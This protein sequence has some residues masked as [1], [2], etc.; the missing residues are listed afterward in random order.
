[1]AKTFF[2]RYA[3]ILVI[4]VVL[5]VLVACAPLPDQSA[6]D[7]FT[8]T[9]SMLDASGLYGVGEDIEVGGIISD[10]KNQSGGKELSIGYPVVTKFASLPDGVR[11]ADFRGGT[12][13]EASANVMKDQL[14]V[15][16]DSEGNFSGSCWYVF[17]EET[18]TNRT[19]DAISFDVSQGQFALRDES[20]GLSYVGTDRPLWHDAWDG[21]NLKQYWIV[22]I[23]AG[24]TLEL[25]LLYAL[26]N[27]VIDDEGLVY[28]VNRGSA[29]GEEGFIGIK[30]FDVAGQ[31]QG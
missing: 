9:A 19:D 4:G 16:P 23:E 6:E 17:G 5:F 20:G 1:M 12:F 8:P 22:S 21:G 24:A 7:S 14:G 31:I 28:L 30:A 27:D 29:S 11:L 25:K 2:K 3:L 18:V 13:D 10:G 26:P 15:M